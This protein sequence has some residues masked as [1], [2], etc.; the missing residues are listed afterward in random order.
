MYC[1][2]CKQ[3]FPGKFCP[4]CGPK[5]VESPT[6]KDIAIN[7]S[8]K[9]AVVGGLNVTRNDSHNTTNYDHRTIYHVA[10]NNISKSV[11]ELKLERTQQFIEYCKQAFNDG[12]LSAEE[13]KHLES[14]RIRLGIDEDVAARL[15]D[16][17]R[18]TSGLLTTL[19]IAD[20][21]T[22]K[23]INRHIDNNNVAML[24]SQMQRFSSL[25]GNYNVEEVFYD[26]YML[27]AALSPAELMHDYEKNDADEYWQTFWAAIAY[28]K[29]GKREETEN[30][31]GKLNR[32]REYPQDNSLLLLALT[33]YNDYGAE[34][35]G[36]Y[37]VSL[38]PE[39][40]SSLLKPFIHALFIEIAPERTSEMGD[41]KDKYRFYIEN[42]VSLENPDAKRK[43][44]E[45]A[46]RKAEEERKRKAEEEA[47]R[48]AEKERKRKAEEEAR[49][50][51]EEE[52]KRKAEEDARR[53]AEEE[54][55][56]KAEEDARRK[57][58]QKAKRTTEE[59]PVLRLA[60]VKNS[61]GSLHYF[62]AEE[63]DANN[64]KS[65]YNKLGVYMCDGNKEFIIAAVDCGSS[66]GKDQF[67]FGA[68]GVE[69]KGVKYH[70]DRDNLDDIWTGE[71]DTRAIIRQTAGKTDEK[72]IVGAPAAEA[73]WNYKACSNDPL[74]WYLPSVSELRLM[75]RHRTKI[76][77]FLDKY[78]GGGGIDEWYWS[79]TLYDKVFSWCV[80]MRGGSIGNYRGVSTRVRAVSF[81]K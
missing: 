43:A 9:A 22:L 32:F 72:G 24:K 35:A 19:S 8:D 39:H 37:I 74:Q 5:L 15:I 66:S 81:A 23:N 30:T 29:Y 16:K 26:Y 40:C 56:R 65:S 11:E 6:E 61:D 18:K 69:I 45:E 42:I 47:H 59:Y 68:Y 60:C 7:L 79:S 50:K 78:F 34:E 14:E 1:P 80:H 38:F 36:E 25:V 3:E 48:K 70:I 67:E 28:M 33:T 53:K 62:T 73:A 71:E 77:K 2:N 49:R 58:A 31:I 57:A 54:R 21:I 51:A 13:Q 27:L 20:T 63:W 10:N 52:R 44:E 46:R 41:N 75:Y 12:I 17:V 76:N 4:E 55:K 64:T